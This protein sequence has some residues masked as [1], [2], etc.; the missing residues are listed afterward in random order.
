MNDKVSS[1]NCELDFCCML[2]YE[3]EVGAWDDLRE[4]GEGFCSAIRQEFRLK[5]TGTERR[6]VILAEE[7]E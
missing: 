5:F 2:V 7:S 1:I 6:V 4:E 3:A